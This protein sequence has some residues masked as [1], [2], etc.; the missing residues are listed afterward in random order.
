MRIG[1]FD[2][3]SKI[4]NLALMKLS[5]HHKSCGDEIIFNFPLLQNSCDK[6]YASIVFSENK[7]KTYELRKDVVIGGS[8]Y[9]YN[10]TLHDT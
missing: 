9:D 4:P 5:A 7:Y 8:G 3:D 6:V 1:L 10:I 2:I